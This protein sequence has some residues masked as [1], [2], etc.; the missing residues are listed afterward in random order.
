MPSLS[1][2]DTRY[3]NIRNSS[4]LAMG[5]TTFPADSGL[6]NLPAA[7]IELSSIFADNLWQGTTFLNNDF[8]LANLIAQRRQQPFGIVHLV[9]HADFQPGSLDNSFIQLQD[10]K[11]PLDQVR[12]LGWNDPPVNLLVLSACQTAVGDREAELGFA[13]LAAKAG[14]LTAVAS[15]WTVNQEGTVA[16]MAEFY[17]QLTQ[18]PIKAEALRQAQIAMIRGEVQ[19]GDGVLRLPDRE[20]P[21]SSDIQEQLG[22]PDLSDP[23][24]WAAFTMIGSP[25]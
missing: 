7:P 10:T 12:E 5:A 25:W 17:R 18:A 11:V 1:L 2:T 9:T 20:I 13:G 15:L 3:T 19:Y 24:Y 23:F 16:L 8:T 6:P 4:V 21:I 14:V 22:S